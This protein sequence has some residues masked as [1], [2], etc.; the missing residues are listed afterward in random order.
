MNQEEKPDEIII[1]DNNC[2]DRTIEIASKYPVTVIKESK[3]G[4]IPARNTGFNS[5]TYEIIAR[6]DADTILPKNWI[7]QIKKTFEQNDVVGLSGNATY[8]D[9]DSPFPLVHWFFLFSHAV[10]GYYILFGPN[11]ALRKD[12]WIAIKDEV[13]LDDSTVHEDIDI[14]IHL[15]KKGQIIY[16][17]NLIVSI[18]ARRIKHNPFSFFIEYPWRWIKTVF[19]H[20]H[21]FYT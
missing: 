14:S 3:Q 9:M 16:D 1:V 15:N 5:A 18:S 6:T 13:C 8:R 12:A 11:L 20:K 17:K 2:T 4:I 19:L 21:T 7:K 10:Q